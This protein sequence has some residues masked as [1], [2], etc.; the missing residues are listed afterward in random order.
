MSALTIQDKVYSI[1]CS[2]WLECQ[3]IPCARVDG[4]SGEDGPGHSAGD[5]L[6]QLAIQEEDDG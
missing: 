4:E 3:D 1:A 6:C 5:N 2:G